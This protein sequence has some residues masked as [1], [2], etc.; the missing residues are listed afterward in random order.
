MKRGNVLV[1]GNSGVGKSTLINA[2]LGEDVAQTGYGTK[3]TTKELKIFENDSIN[4]RLIDSV[5]FEP[6]FFKRRKAINSVRDWTKTA[7]KAGDPNSAINVIWFCVDGTSRKLFPQSID[8]LAR[9]VSVFKTVPIIV[10]ITKSYSEPDRTE[11]ISMVQ[12]AFAR[13]HRKLNLEKIIP[14]VAEIYHLNDQAFAAQEGISELIDSTNAVMP[15]GIAAA[16]FDINEYKLQRKNTFAHGVVGASTV[17]GVATAATT[18]IPMTDAVVLSGIESAEVNI[19]A[20][21]YG[22]KKGNKQHVLIERIVEIGTVSA[23]ARAACAAIMR[24]V[25]LAGT[26]VNMIVAGSFVAAIGEGTRYIFEQIYLGKKSVEDIDWV[27]KVLEEKLS[28]GFID[29]V[30][31]ASAT[32]NE[33]SSKE[34]VAKAIKAVFDK[35][36]PSD[37]K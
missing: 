22:I 33:M 25:P 21:V 3:G 32:L 11:N 15:E 34:D 5:G 17:A 12:E 8:S 24:A 35:E 18:I 7:A 37:K 10:V 30:K 4:F 26:V 29:K 27:E 2:V 19:L 16:E 9:A 20:R 13:R 28:G 6:D 14:V 1:L 36:E 23:V 31:N